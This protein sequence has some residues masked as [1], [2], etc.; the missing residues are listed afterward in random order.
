MS[1]LTPTLVKVVFLAFERGAKDDW[2]CF[3]ADGSEVLFTR[4]RRFAAWLAWP[5]SSSLLVASATTGTLRRLQRGGVGKANWLLAADEATL[6][7]DGRRWLARPGWSPRAPWK[8]EL[9]TREGARRQ[10]LFLCAQDGQRRVQLTPYALDAKH[11]TWSPDGA[12][13]AFSAT[14]LSGSPARGIAL[15]SLRWE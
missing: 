6:E 12:T 8:I 2:P 7:V 14:L 15:A 9:I 13:I 10:A 3:S 5:T 11:P 1:D 4:R